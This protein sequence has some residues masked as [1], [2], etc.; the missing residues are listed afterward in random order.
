MVLNSL[1]VIDF[2][3]FLKID[4]PPTHPLKNFS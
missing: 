3:N 1:Y 2:A 4:I